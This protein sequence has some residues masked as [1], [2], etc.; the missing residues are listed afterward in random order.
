[1]REPSTF[2]RFAAG[3]AL[4]GLSAMGVLVLHVSFDALGAAGP[5][6]GEPSLALRDMYG[7]VGYI[8]LFGGQWLG[9]FFVLSG[10]LISRPFVRSYVRDEPRPDVPRYALNRVLRIVPAFW[11]AVFATLLVFG[12][13]GSPPW[14]VPLTLA[15]GQGLAPEETFITYIAQGWTLGT[16]V[17]FYALVPVLALLATRRN[18]RRWAGRGRRGTSG[19]RAANILG[20]CLAMFAAS[21][22]WRELV[23]EGVLAWFY[24]FPA[25]AGAFAPGVAL[26]VAEATWPER[27]G[28]L[29]RRGLAAALFVSGI[30]LMCVAVSVT[31]VSNWGRVVSAWIGAGLIVGGALVREWSG[32]PPWRALS[33]GV[34]D[35]LGQRSYSIYVLHYGIAIWVTEQVVV[36]GHQRETLLY[37]APLTVMVTLVLATLSWN[38]VEQPF[39]RLRKRWAR[40]RS[41]SGRP[42]PASAQPMPSPAPPAG[43]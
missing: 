31:G 3:D 7:P 33:N 19:R 5:I 2:G 18:R 41:G 4:R 27:L 13:K 10:Y 22:A 38:L 12:L 14:V 23:P 21:V 9:V 42:A 8:A 37:A 1:M 39:L 36:H 34:T 16:E 40:P 32:A 43:G 26:A 17:V 35:W 25:V 11:V 24:V 6:L 28:G 15:F 29:S 20:L 30:A